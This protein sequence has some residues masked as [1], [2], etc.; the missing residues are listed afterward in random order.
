[1]NRRNN[2]F[3]LALSNLSCDGSSTCNETFIRHAEQ[4]K[5]KELNSICNKTIVKKSEPKALEIH[6]VLAYYVFNNS[7][8]VLAVA[9]GNYK[10]NPVAKPKTTFSIDNLYLSENKDALP[11]L[12][13]CFKN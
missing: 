12:R 7:F 4:I 10:G 1:M 3:N 8:V 9:L 13:F 6:T 11:Y 5:T 2:L